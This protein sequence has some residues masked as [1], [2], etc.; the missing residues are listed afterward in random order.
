MNTYI[1]YI[2]FILS[3][4]IEGAYKNFLGALFTLYNVNII[5]IFIIISFIYYIIY[6]F[7][8]LLWCFNYNKR[9]I[10]IVKCLKVKGDYKLI[11]FLFYDCVGDVSRGNLTTWRGELKL[12][13][14][15]TT[16]NV[17][18]MNYKNFWSKKN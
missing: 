9:V 13:R 8:I 7:V 4:H 5:L 6:I 11:L 3:L 10:I 12:P 1:Y 2:Q 16:W 14:F 18:K 17:K 15:R